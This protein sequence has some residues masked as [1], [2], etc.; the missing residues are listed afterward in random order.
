M[1]EACNL[2]HVFK[3]DGTYVPYS[4]KRISNA[5]YRAAVAVGGRDKD[6]ADELSLKIESIICENYSVEHPPMVEQIQDIV[7]KVLIEEGHATVAKH[8]IVYRA[9]QNEKRKA[10]LSKSTVHTGNIPYQKIYEVLVWASDHDLN[11]VEKLNQRIGRGEFAQIC[12][13]SDKAYEYDVQAAA[14][15]ITERD[16]D[17]RIV[18]VAGP[19]SS[20]KTTTTRKLAHYLSKKG[21]G[22][23]ELNVDH[24]FFDLAMHPVDEF[25]DHDFETPQALDLP[26]INQHIKQLLAGEEVM[27]PSY[28][29]KTGTRTLDQISMKIKPTD[30]ILIDSL[31]GLYG[32]MLNGI[33]ESTVFK[34][35]IETLLQMKGVNGK[36]IR[37]TD[38][39]LMRRMIRDE[40]HRAYDPRQT[41]THWHYVRNAELRNILPYITTADYVINGAVPYELPVMRNRLLEHFK[42]WEQDYKDDPRRVDAYLRA[43]RV[44]EMLESV[45][46]VTDESAIPETSHFREFIGG[47]IYDVH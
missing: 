13:E 3:R 16:G 11:S 34:V 1:S 25:G 32:D 5:I 23:V 17:T 20:G 43:K 27:T 12:L 4:R 26:L 39:R 10:K 45:T 30:V 35:Y 37:W 38:L 22:L 21:M 42:E 36:F 2:T 8:F 47:S 31:H 46:P 28:D 7:E 24:Y 14:E 41:L 33:D 44:R 6:K 18:V 40:Q 15:L 9:T 29:F 19:S